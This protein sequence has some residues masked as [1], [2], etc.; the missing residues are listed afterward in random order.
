[1]LEY[2]VN[3]T[4]QESVGDHT[5]QLLHEIV[6]FAFIAALQKGNKTKII[7]TQ[8][9]IGCWRSLKY[10]ASKVLIMVLSF[11]VINSKIY[12]VFQ[13]VLNSLENFDIMCSLLKCSFKK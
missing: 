3:G 9:D 6:V 2:L 13:G 11:T 4:V 12:Y 5:G 8:K 7:I 10:S 1:M